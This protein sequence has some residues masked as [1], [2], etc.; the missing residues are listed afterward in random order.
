M[1]YRP[2]GKT[3]LKVSEIGLGCRSLGGKAVINGKATTFGDISSSKAENI[4]QFALNSGINVFDTS[5]TYSLGNSESRLGKTLLDYR[6]DVYIFTKGGAVPSLNNPPF[7]IDL[8]FSHL[9]SAI[10]RSLNRLQTDYVDLYQTHA[11]PKSENDFDNLENFFSFIKSENKALYVGVS[12]GTNFDTGIELIKRKLIDSL[13]ITYSLLNGNLAKKLLTL[14]KKEQIALIAN[15]P[16][17][18]GLLTE[19]FSKKI[20]LEDDFR[21]KYS[22]NF[23]KSFNLKINKILTLKNNSMKLDSLALSYV[24]HQKEISVCLTGVSNSS[25]LNSNISSMEQTLDLELIEKI[26]KIQESW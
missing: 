6:N 18:E 14:C 16:F 17:A 26:T 20:F 4:I 15:R 22:E 21:K 7:E 9:S 2:F 3:G 8:S 12:I 11:S 25:Q 24:L 23:F 5:D 13:Q 19:N 10:N 1:K